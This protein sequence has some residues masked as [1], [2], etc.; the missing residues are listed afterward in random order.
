M[1]ASA[2]CCCCCCCCCCVIGGNT[3]CQVPYSSSRHTSR[4]VSVDS[5]LYPQYRC[6]LC[7]SLPGGLKHHHNRV[8]RR[9]LYVCGSCKKSFNRCYNFRSHQ[10]LN[11]HSGV[12]YKCKECGVVSNNEIEFDQHRFSIHHNSPLRSS[13]SRT[14]KNTFSN[15]IFRTLR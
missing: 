14:V 1:N 11:K 12:R 10:K 2:C 4:I 9:L 13:S 6:R 7:D 5:K 8:H 15:R 3:V